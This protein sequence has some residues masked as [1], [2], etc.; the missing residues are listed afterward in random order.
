MGSTQEGKG[1]CASITSSW[2]GGGRYRQLTVAS[3]LDS[4]PPSP[5]KGETLP[6]TPP[7]G[8]QGELLWATG[9]QGHVSPAGH[10]MTWGGQSAIQAPAK[11]I[12]RSS[13]SDGL[14]SSTRVLQRS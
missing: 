6:T 7:P 4:G 12:R 14:W 3:S 13:R 1:V 10:H 2:G 9:Q 8:Q 11:A 5:E